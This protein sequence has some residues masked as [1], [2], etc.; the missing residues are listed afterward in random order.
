MKL[1]EGLR[2]RLDSGRLDHHAMTALMLVSA[3]RRWWERILGRGAGYQVVLFVENI[4]G[5]RR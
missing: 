2:C 3:D 4:L 5:W 1:T